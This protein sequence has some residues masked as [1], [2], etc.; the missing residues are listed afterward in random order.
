MAGDNFRLKGIILIRKMQGF[1]KKGIFSRDD[2]FN[3]WYRNEAWNNMK[4]NFSVV[5]EYVD[6]TDVLGFATASMNAFK[7]DIFAK[8][9]K[10]PAVLL[11]KIAV[12]DSEEA[13]QKKVAKMLIGHI[14]KLANEEKEKIGCR[15]VVV[16]VR[17]KNGE[18]NHK[19]IKYYE[20]FGF[21]KCDQT[22]KYVTLFFDLNDI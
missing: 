7:I 1:P 3:Q 20:K 19:L 11:G 5:Y 6:G 10:I 14:I 16:Q 12:N 18:P 9:F 2:D 13:K 21:E 17:H 22:K 8:K 4:K 15:I